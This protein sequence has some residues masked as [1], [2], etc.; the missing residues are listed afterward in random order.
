MYNRHMRFFSIAVLLL[1]AGCSGKLVKADSLT[2]C[3][4]GHCETVNDP[5]SRDRLL[6]GLHG[7][8]RE[9]KGREIAIYSAKPGTRAEK[10]RGVSFYTQGGPM[11]G[12][13]TVS[14]LKV[15]EVFFLDRERS[16]VKAAARMAVAWFGVPLLC[17]ESSVSF[18]AGEAQAGMTLTNI[19]TWIGIGTTRTKFTWAIDKVDLDAGTAS[20]PWSVGTA[21]L[22]VI[23][24]GSGYMLARFRGPAPKPAPAPVEPAPKPKPAAPPPPPAPVVEELSEAPE[25]AVSTR[26]QDEDGDMLLS[27]G[28]EI[29]LSVDVQ[30][31]GTAE[32]AAVKIA[33]SGEAALVSCLGAGRELG[34]SAPGKTL[35]ARF[36]CRLPAQVPSATVRLV[37]E[38]KSGAQGTL[39]G[40][41]ILKVGMK[42]KAVLV[43]EA[44]SELSVDDIPARRGGDSPN[45]GLVIGLTRYREKSIPAVRFAAR[46]AEV[47][48]RYLESVAEVKAE[49]LKVITDDNA[50]KSDLE[51][52]FEDWLPR[53]VVPESTVYVYYSGHGAPDV[54]GSEAYL[55]PFEGHADF[56]SKLYPL[57]RMYEALAKLPAKAVVVMLDSCFSGAKGRGLSREGARPLVPALE[58]AP[59]PG[60]KV[61]VLAGASGSQIASDLDSVEHGL[62]TYYLLKGLRGEADA[63]RDGVVH[64]GELFSFAKENVSRK[65]S[66]ELN[67]DQTPVFIGE[68]ESSARVPMARR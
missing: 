68:L 24:R 21:G 23:G 39:A 53:H 38:V 65:A 14:G 13:S 15:N 37:V 4:Q 62:F 33:L 10:K 52:Y 26:L 42:P 30:N 48:G 34:L 51:A 31:R 27:G 63:D 35:A 6:S 56:P 29:A 61:S 25:L 54:T 17:T 59:A 36:K 2:L 57:K 58:K 22:P 49:H 8:L 44:V 20:G 3:G 16:E 67:R 18:S 64:L 12:W 19:C 66:A 45:V 50:T 5:G 32:A 28:E 11:P 60:G 47:M 9:A 43:E 55:V 46:D 1:L 40:G 41:K 7:L